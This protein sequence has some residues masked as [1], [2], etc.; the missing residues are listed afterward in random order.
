MT[1]WRPLR[2]T[3]RLTSFV[4][5]FALSSSVQTQQPPPTQA[6]PSTVALATPSPDEDGFYRQGPGIVAPV[7]VNPKAVTGLTGFDD[8]V[9][10]CAP[11][12]V[13]ISAVIDTR[14]AAAVREPQQAPYF[15]C[16]SAA[17]GAILLSRFQAGTLNNQPVQVLVCL[18][19]SFLKG[20]KKVLPTIQPCP[21]NLSTATFDGQSIYRAGGAVKPPVLTFQP[22]VKYSDEARRKYLQ[23]V[24]IIGLI[25]DV[26]GN[27]QNVHVVRT[28]GMGLDEKAMEAVR[29]YRF[30]PATLN[31]IPV[32]VPITVEMD[33]HL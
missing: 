6:D 16:E 20:A 5:L 9:K 30:K 19:V 17:I 4:A 13:V 32:P 26:R 8:P 11:R 27:P 10:E 12:T 15:S 2:H 31:G 21:E 3:I 25:V 23:G 28:L 18:G 14:G 22:E 33:F 24:C 29:L 7:L 1:W